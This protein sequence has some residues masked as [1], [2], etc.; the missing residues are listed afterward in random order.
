MRLIDIFI[1]T[2]E[3]LCAA[4]QAK[5]GDKALEA[6]TILLMQIFDHCGHLEGTFDIMFPFLERLK[7]KIEAGD[8]MAA[9]S[10]A[11]ALLEKF[12]ALRQPGGRKRKSAARLN[13]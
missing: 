7:E 3:I 13:S 2:T 10:D 4:I 1:E 9:E 5:D 11:L 6:V 12:Q 8:Y